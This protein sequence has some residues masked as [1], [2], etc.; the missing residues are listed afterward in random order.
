[1]SELEG[2]DFQCPQFPYASVNP[3]L[4]HV[5]LGGM[6]AQSQAQSQGQMQGG[7]GMPLA[8]DPNLFRPRHGQGQAPSGAA[9][10][11]FN[12]GQMVDSEIGEQYDE[13]LVT[14]KPKV[15]AKSK[16]KSTI[17]TKTTTKTRI[18]GDEGDYGQEEDDN[19][20]DGDEGDVEVGAARS[21][22]KKTS[23]ARK[24]GFWVHFIY[25]IV[26]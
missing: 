25:H 26:L 12:G 17:K 22:G 19:D 23:H 16:S 18:G 11:T 21:S 6:G 20:D 15:K 5:Q 13:D 1:M 2:Y 9:T 7:M 8:I 10:T 14:A 4:L 24:V 3:G